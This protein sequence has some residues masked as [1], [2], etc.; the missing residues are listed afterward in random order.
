MNEVRELGQ[1]LI[2]QGE[3]P[4]THEVL[5]AICSRRSVRQFTDTPLSGEDVQILLEAGLRAPSSRGAHTTQFVLVEDRDTLTELSYMRPSGAD[6]LR[7]VPLGIVILGSPMECEKWIADATL[8][9]GYLQLQAEALGLGSCWANVY[10]CYTPNGQESVEYVRNV[11]DIPYQLEVL[12]IIAIGHKA[13]ET[14][15]HPIEELR[16]EQI[17]LERYSLPEEGEQEG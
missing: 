7:Q 13:H 15:P 4:H 16:W 10:G 2:E 3:V 6:F 11:L 8:A 1:E 17:H 9:A 14:T 12:C 5:P